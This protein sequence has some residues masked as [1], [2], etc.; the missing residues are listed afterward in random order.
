MTVNHWVNVKSKLFWENSL[1]FGSFG[2]VVNLCLGIL[3]GCAVPVLKFETIYSHY[4]QR[5]AETRSAA[6][7]YQLE[8]LEELEELE[9]S[10][11]L[12]DRVT[13]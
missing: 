7:W 11:C 2:F 3:K 8:E 4:D 10:K 1:V 5:Q 13:S 9:D 12:P 6:I